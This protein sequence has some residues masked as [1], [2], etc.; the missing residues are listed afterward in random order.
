MATDDAHFY[1]PADG[2]RLSHDPFKAILGPRP[3]GWV[4]SHDAEGRP[5]LAPYSFFNAFN[6]APPI[7]GFASADWKHSV[8]NLEAT[9]VFCWNLVTR[10]LAEPMNATS[11]AVPRGADEFA[12][13]GLTASPG[14][15]VSAPRVRES[16]VN[17]ECR[18]TDII[19]LR[20]GEGRALDTWLTLGEVVAVH[21]E[22]H[23][24][25]DGVYDTAS[26]HPVLRAGGAG[27]YAEI[28][29]GAMFTMRRPA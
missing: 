20:T 26:A 8:A 2:H 3:I 13:A 18:V 7:L 5:N 1:Q 11:E 17:L 16:P 19:R 22:R 10:A 23:L 21:I 28:T 6:D 12:L 25:R 14:R 15:V 27:D 24:L 29:P 4:S 9:G